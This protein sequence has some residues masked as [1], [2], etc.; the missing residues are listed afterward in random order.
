[1]GWV[2]AVAARGAF[3]GQALGARGTQVLSGVRASPSASPGGAPTVDDLRDAVPD[4]GEIELAGAGKHTVWVDT[5]P[6]AEGAQVGVVLYRVDGRTVRLP[7]DPPSRI[8]LG[9]SARGKPRAVYERCLDVCGIWTYDFAARRERRV[10]AAGHRDGNVI[11]ASVWGGHLAYARLFGR[12]GR[13]RVVLAGLRGSS[14]R[15]L[16]LD[17]S[18]YAVELGPDAIAT[19]SG[20]R[21]LRVR[22]RRRP[23]VRFTRGF[24]IGKR[25]ATGIGAL[26]YNGSDLLWKEV[27]ACGCRYQRER[28]YRLRA[29]RVTQLARRRTPLAVR[30]TQVFAPSTQASAA[31]PEP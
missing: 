7:I 8:D 16:F 4:G 20:G 28:F 3:D 27:E 24:K 25:C 30:L 17:E 26:Q 12:G 31:C 10:R 9:L 22:S 14:R 21:V 6:D 11:F 18:L 19:V 1:M 29:G 13:D 2:P 15:T 23:T 5:L